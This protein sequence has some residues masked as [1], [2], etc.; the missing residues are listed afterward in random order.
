MTQNTNLNSLWCH[1]NPLTGSL[2]LN[3]LNLL[4]DF[5]GANNPSLECIQVDNAANADAGIG[6]YMDW[7][8]DDTAE[9]SE[10][11]FYTAIPDTNFEAILA[12][13]DD[14]SG[15]NL[16]PTANIEGITFLDVSYQNIADLSGIE[17]F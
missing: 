7:L 1:N 11:C 13:Y 16:I 12:A 9:Y 2:I 6:Q 8:K 4:T 15:D 17:E 5:V 14:I 3:G 10:H